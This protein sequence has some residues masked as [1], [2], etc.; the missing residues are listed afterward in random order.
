MVLTGNDIVSMIKEM[1]EVHKKTHFKHVHFSPSPLR[2][3]A[4][5]IITTDEDDN[6]TILKGNIKGSY[7]EGYIDEI[8]KI[9]DDFFIKVSTRSRVS[10][11][12]SDSENILHDHINSLIQLPYITFIDIV[13][14]YDMDKIE[15]LD[16]RIFHTY[17]FTPTY[18]KYLLEE[19]E[20][21]EVR[22]AEINKKLPF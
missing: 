17:E 5:Q 2:F 16:E 10:F 22:I 11:Y 9:G 21:E 7:I 14:E 15:N 3:A 6:E 4:K 8:S 12:Y 18:G 13:F 1:L 19:N 20:I